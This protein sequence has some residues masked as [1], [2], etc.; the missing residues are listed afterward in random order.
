[1]KPQIKLEKKFQELFDNI[2]YAIAVYEARR[3]GQDFIFK[4]FNRQAELI[5]N[6]RKKDLIGQSVLKMFPGVKDL[7]LFAVFQQVW[8]TGIPEHLPVSLYEDNR[9]TGWREN[10]I[11][12]LSTG[13]IVAAYTDETETR[14]TMENLQKSKKQID[15]IIN[16]FKG[17]IYTVSSDYKIEFMNKALIKDVGQDALGKNCYELIH[18]FKDKCSWCPQDK[19]L[20]GKTV[21]FESKSPKNNKWYYYIASPGL[22]SVGKISGQQV[23]VIDINDRKISE[24]KI[25][26]TQKKLQLENKLLKSASVN[27]YGLANIVGQS[28]KMQ[29][30]YNLILEVTSSDASVLIHG[31]SGTGKELVANAI[32]TLGERKNQPFLPVNC[33]G[34]P[35]NLIESEFFGYKK[36]AFTGANIDKSGFL[37]I[38]DKGTLFLDEIGEIN[39][40]MQ[41]K[42][43][44]AIDGDGHT[45]L[46]SSMP[47]KT[48]IRII[49]ATNKDLDALVKKGFMRP[50]FF[51]RINVVPIHLPPLR[52]R[53]EDIVLLIYHFLKKFSTGKTLP[54]I[55]PKIMK[56][57]ENHD[58]P[59]NVRELQNIIHRYIALNRLDVFDSFGMANDE[60]KP[61]QEIEPDL[62]DKGLNLQGSIQNYEKKI[63]ALY[64]KKNQWKQGK[65]ASILGINRKTLF[66]KIKKY[67]ITKF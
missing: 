44:R 57:L 13:E 19:V 31:E 7:G 16:S 9:L 3:D 38:A 66:S 30:V 20:S 59:G 61:L 12:R 5:D 47:V 14:L 34:I 62:N 51:Y 18:G 63:I 43:L 6:I 17:F 54:H 48:D 8:K 24:Q 53:R 15:L 65:V 2:N 32:H 21:S 45:P 27:R 64:L 58:W 42:L 52:K 55:P 56:A 50:D 46:G 40:N 49:A 10:F 26:E 28:I 1:M 60:N 11:Y 67:G 4:Y 22:D 25:A 36:G 23:I 29:E 39:L 37:E 41:V 35:E 33:G